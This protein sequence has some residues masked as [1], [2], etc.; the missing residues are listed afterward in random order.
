MTNENE[1]MNNKKRHTNQ[2]KQLKELIKALSEIDPNITPEG[3]IGIIKLR[4]AEKKKEGK[5]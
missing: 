5:K 3:W 4:D 1:L 2:R